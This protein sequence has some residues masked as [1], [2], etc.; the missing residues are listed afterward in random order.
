MLLYEHGKQQSRKRK[1]KHPVLESE[2]SAALQALMK[3]FARAVVY[4]PLV[5][6]KK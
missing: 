6:A 4:Y 2:D 1:E 3:R 5:N